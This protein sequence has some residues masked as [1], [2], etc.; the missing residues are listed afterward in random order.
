MT[1]LLT[2][3][4]KRHPVAGYAD[5]QLSEGLE[6]L[7]H[8]TLTMAGNRNRL[9]LLL[10]SFNYVGQLKILGE[11]VQ[12]SVT[13]G[14]RVSTF[15][16]LEFRAGITRTQVSETFLTETMLAW[17]AERIGV[18]LQAYRAGNVL[19]YRWRVLGGHLDNT[20]LTNNMRL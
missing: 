3:F 18:D 10:V 6:R 1:M 17:K 11:Y 14:Y 5:C 7:A 13:K 12:P 8:H 4:T 16:A 19:L 15:R 20:Y 2:T 9:T